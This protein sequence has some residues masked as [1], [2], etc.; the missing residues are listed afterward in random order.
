MWLGLTLAVYVSKLSRVE[1]VYL[2]DAG[3]TF[4]LE[5]VFLSFWYECSTACKPYNQGQ[6]LVISLLPEGGLDYDCV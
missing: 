6:G 3:K 4:Y 2:C 5:R 1:K